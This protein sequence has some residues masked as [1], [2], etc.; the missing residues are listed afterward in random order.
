MFTGAYRFY[1]FAIWALLLRGSLLV[2][3]FFFPGDRPQSREG[4]GNGG[5]GQ[6]NDKHKKLNERLQSSH[7]RPREAG[8]AGAATTEQKVQPTLGEGSRP[9][10]TVP[11][12]RE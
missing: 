8:K 11:C 6:G 12:L 3:V 10:T 2:P 9:P 7:G 5:G 1:N 4:G